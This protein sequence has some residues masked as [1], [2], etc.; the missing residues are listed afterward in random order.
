MR[1]I[2]FLLP[3]VLF[4][5]LAGYF[6]LAL[7]PD[8]DPKELPSAMI[9]KEAPAFTLAGLGDAPG[10]DRTVFQ[11]QVVLVNFFASWCVPCRAE[12]PLLLRLSKEA[13]PPLYR[14]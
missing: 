4:L 2:L 9:D 13:G 6:A 12:H 5:T 10:L 3:I 8:R 11:G 14:I 7:R 1:R